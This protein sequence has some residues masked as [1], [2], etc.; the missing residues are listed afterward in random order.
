MGGWGM[1]VTDEEHDAARAAARL[2]AL[3]KEYTK[4]LRYISTQV[5]ELQDRYAEAKSLDEQRAIKRA[6]ADFNA[7]RFGY[8]R[9]FS[10]ATDL[11]RQASQMVEH[12]KLE[13]VA[14]LDL[15]LRAAEF[16]ASLQ[17]AQQRIS[18]G[19]EI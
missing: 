12:G 15:S 14:R 18:A 16:E 11:A 5:R 2:A 10:A 17:E 19:P 6:E 1:S 9:L 13:T 8:F 3:L 4:K 7:I